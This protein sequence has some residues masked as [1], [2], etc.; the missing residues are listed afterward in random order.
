MIIRGANTMKN[1]VV[2]KDGF[3]LVLPSVMI[4]IQ[5]LYKNHQCAIAIILVLVLIWNIKITIK[6][7]AGVLIILTGFILS[8]MFSGI[9]ANFLYE[10]L[11]LVLLF[12][13]MSVCAD[14]DKR[15]L[16]FGFYAGISL[17]S[18]I[19]I[20]SYIMNLNFW[21]YI[22]IIDGNRILQ[23]PFGYANTMALFSGIAIVISLY[24]ITARKEY[25]FIFELLF[26]INVI[27]FVLAKSVFG[28]VCLII[29]VVVCLF[30]G[31]KMSRKYIITFFAMLIICV[32][33]VLLTGNEEVF[34]HSTVASR[35]IYWYDAFGVIL[36]HPFGVGV[37][38]WE[39]IQY[40]VQSA[41]Y[42]VKY[43]H[44]GYIQLLLDGGFTA[45]IGF[46]VITVNGY[47]GLKERYME[48]KDNTYLVLICILTF[49]L[50][51]SFVDI[52]FAYGVVWFLFGLILSCSKNDKTKSAKC[53]IPI[54]IVAVLITTV[55]QEK[56]YINPY[57]A[58]FRQAY[59]KNDIKQ[60]NEVSLKWI[61]NAPRQQAA[62]DARYYVLGKLEDDERLK[63]LKIYANS[64]NGTMNRLCKYLSTHKEI[65]LPEVKGK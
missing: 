17:A 33:A 60:M 27:S 54:I 35:L 62:Y 14:S 40:M 11:K 29:S 42:S 41:D 37:H 59:E 63:E 12:L 58:E 24:F 30:V 18:L 4:F 53:I 1:G 15:I 49:I 7:S 5:G 2:F 19:G 6:Q 13:G 28:Y 52:H 31:V 44:N 61:E 36:K 51:H 34:I 55:V 50:I 64:I 25:R 3:L 65:V 9:S 21:N 8:D 57:P 16:F 32:V 45:L 26:L 43:V 20:I 38:K 47:T 46:L 10:G 39:E 56:E 22:N 48:T 23:G